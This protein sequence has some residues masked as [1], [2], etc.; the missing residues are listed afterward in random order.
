MLESVSD[1]HSAVI[2]STAVLIT[3]KPPFTLEGVPILSYNVTI[4]NTISGENETI[5]VEDTTLLYSIDTNNSH[6]ATVVPINEAG[7]GDP[8]LIIIEISIPS[9]MM[10]TPVQGTILNTHTRKC[11]QFFQSACIIRHACKVY[12]IMSSVAETSETKR[13]ISTPM[14]SPVQGIYNS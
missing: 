12:K 5:P 1:L 2:N 3:W 9:L 10:F 14:A 8:A 6:T 4:S 13:S 7:K 11:I